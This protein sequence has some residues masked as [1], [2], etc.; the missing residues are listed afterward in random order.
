[1]EA[2]G[3]IPATAAMK[4]ALADPFARLFLMFNFDFSTGNE[5]VCTLPHS[6]TWNTFTWDGS[7]GVVQVGEFQQQS[8]TLL[9]PFSVNL[10]AGPIHATRITDVL[11]ASRGR[12]AKWWVAV[13]NDAGAIVADPVQMPTRIMNPGSVRGG[14][15]YTIEV[16]LESRFNRSRVRAPKTAS[17]QEQ[18]D[19]DATDFALFDVGKLP[20]G[21][22]RFKRTLKSGFSGS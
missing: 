15:T 1:M 14:S 22:G 13:L 10:S 7:A 6:V 12:T 8:D 11:T 19:L 18:Q 2:G 9:S 4:T 3:M 17:H 21:D 16:V 5:R 20:R